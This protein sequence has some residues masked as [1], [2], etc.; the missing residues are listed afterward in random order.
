M[1]L[2]KI[3][4]IGASKSQRFGA[5]LIA[6]IQDYCSEHNIQRNQMSGLVAEALAVKAPKIDTK[7][8]SFE[9]FKAGKTIDEI[10]LERSFARSTIEGHLAHFVGLGELDIFTVMDREKV[11]ELEG[12][13]RANNTASS[14]EAKAHFEEQYSYGDIKMVLG[15]LSAGEEGE[16]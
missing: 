10:A 8:V 15:Y 9:L 4:G 3:K 14:A 5:E 7:T 13:F 16:G 6:I 11:E 1:A 2:K 12:F